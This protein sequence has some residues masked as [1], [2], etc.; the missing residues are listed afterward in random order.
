[1]VNTRQILT[2]PITLH[3]RI[4]WLCSKQRIVSISASRR[5]A[6]QRFIQQTAMLRGKSQPFAKRTLSVALSGEYHATAVRTQRPNC[7]IP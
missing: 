4:L 3:L 2:D 1:M 5:L 7:C 6:E